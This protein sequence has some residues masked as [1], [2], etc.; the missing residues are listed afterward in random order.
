MQAP[1]C[2]AVL[3]STLGKQCCTSSTGSHFVEALSYKLVL[4][5]F[6]VRARQYEVVLG[7]TLGKLCSTK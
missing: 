7:S 2:K 3:G 1:Y 6:I 4:R 5:S